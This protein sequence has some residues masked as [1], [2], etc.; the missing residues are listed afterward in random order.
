MIQPLPLPSDELQKKVLTFETA[1]PKMR[2]KSPV[3][4]LATSDV[5]SA[6]GKIFVTLRRSILA[7]QE[8]ASSSYVV[9]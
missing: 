3:I 8:K 6:V 2:R 7:Q 9:Y 1:N 5:G 4:K